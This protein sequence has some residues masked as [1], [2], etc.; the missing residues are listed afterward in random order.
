MAD[1]LYRQIA[2][3][4]RQQIESGALPP[5]GQ[6][7]T[8][9]ELRERYSASRNTIRDAL[10]WLTA[11]GLIDAR[12]G[13]GTFVLE[14]IDP[15]VTTLS[16]H[17]TVHLADEAAGAGRRSSVSDPRVEVQKAAGD[18]AVMLRLP[19]GE[20]VISRQQ[21]RYVDGTIWSLQASFYPRE[22]VT[23]GAELLL[24]TDDIPSGV[25]AYL[26]QALGLEQVGYEDRIRAGPPGKEEAGL[27]RLAD[28]GR[29]SVIT[30]HRTGYTTGDQGPVPFRVTI[31]AF[32][33]D[34]NQLLIRSGHVPEYSEPGT[35]A[36]TT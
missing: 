5:G 26:K 1:P 22:L 8:E 23:R 28:D 24:R 18:I 6:V 13:Q 3:D 25:L 35:P 16:P 11:R 19:E 7:P 27:L 34:R 17:Q 15:F 31:T 10:R 14:R 36:D 21:I 20:E 32:P 12:A 4:L 33:A 29:V 30:V 9:L 2:E